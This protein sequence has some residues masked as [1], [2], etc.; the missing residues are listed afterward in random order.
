M[1]VDLVL[2]IGQSNMAG[3]GE[4][5]DRFPEEAPKLI[6]G[7]G[8]EYRA[9]SAPNTLFP[10]EEPFGVNENVKNGIY[11]VF[12]GERKAKTGSL[13]TA[14]CNAYFESTHT[15]IVGVSASKGGSSIAEWLPDA[16][17]NY[18][19]DALSRYLKAKEY[20]CKENI[21]LNR[22]FAVWCQ[23]E[24]DGDLGTSV[25]TYL[26]SFDAVL[27]EINKNIPDLFMIKIGEC[28]IEGAYNRYSQIRSAQ[29]LIISKYPNVHLCS[30]GFFGL[31]EKGLMK[32][33][34]HYYQTGYN[35]V[36]TEA[37]FNVGRHIINS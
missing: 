29:D 17:T 5:C 35:Y 11:D 1:T 37:G 16:P 14:F 10:I 12:E 3:R 23:G 13:V 6:P 28:N 15:P 32:D 4:V 24:T 18:L 27:T 21:T 25:N 19:R 36:G 26:E 20:L 22:T 30:D 31:R 2:F 9:I 8:Y 34:F 7:A 33:A